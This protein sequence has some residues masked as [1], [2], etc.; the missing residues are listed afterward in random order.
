MHTW[1]QLKMPSWGL[2]TCLSSNLSYDLRPTVL[3]QLMYTD[4]CIPENFL[5]DL[6]TFGAMAMGLKTFHVCD[7][8]KSSW[9]C[10]DVKHYVSLLE[11]QKKNDMIL[12]FCSRRCKRKW[13][14]V[15]TDYIIP[16]PEKSHGHRSRR[17]TRGSR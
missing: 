13:K 3:K 8:C 10:M 17:T 6:S 11:R 7:F 15:N 2:E 16:K 1:T 9:D 4:V 5:P 14:R 12:T